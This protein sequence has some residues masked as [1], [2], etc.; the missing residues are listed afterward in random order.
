MF[1]G[2]T[3]EI[4]TTMTRREHR[5]VSN[6]CS[7]TFVYF[8][9]SIILHWRV[10]MAAADHDV[11]AGVHLRRWSDRHWCVLGAIWKKKVK[12]KDFIFIIQIQIFSF[13]KVFFNVCN[14]HIRHQYL[15][16]LNLFLCVFSE[17]RCSFQSLW[18][19]CCLNK[20][21]VLHLWVL[22]S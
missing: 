19:T 17:N 13:C 22:R 21:Q 3:A 7:N 15:W 20:A 4:L 18:R 11:A 16:L 5:L 1:V 6:I 12:L 10:C 9:P 2:G 14:T 8:K